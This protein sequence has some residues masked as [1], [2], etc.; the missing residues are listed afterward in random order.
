MNRW[1]VA[2][3]PGDP[4]VVVAADNC[5]VLPSGALRLSN[6]VGALVPVPVR[7]YSPTGWHHFEPMPTPTEEP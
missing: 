7:V 6:G 3:T 1:R 5:D 4:G 2:Q